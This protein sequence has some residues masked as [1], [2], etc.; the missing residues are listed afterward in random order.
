MYLSF[1]SPKFIFLITLPLTQ[2]FWRKSLVKQLNQFLKSVLKNCNLQILGKRLEKQNQVILYFYEK[3]WVIKAFIMTFQ[4]MLWKT[5][6]NYALSDLRM[7]K[8]TIYVYHTHQWHY[9]FYITSNPLISR[10]L[11]NDRFL[12]PF[13]IEKWL[14]TQC[15]HTEINLLHYSKFCSIYIS[16][17]QNSVWP[18]S[19]FTIFTTLCCN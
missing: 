16:N 17:E 13:P 8:R 6:C 15:G 12:K 7:T 18:I 2:N 11:L 4:Q 5:C 14:L 9:I 19:F 1:V 3:I 10:Y